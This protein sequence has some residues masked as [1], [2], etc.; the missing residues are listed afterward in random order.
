MYRINRTPMVVA[1]VL[2]IA[3]VVG[4]LVGTKIVWDR[5]RNQPVSLSSLPGDPGP[6][7]T[8]LLPHLPDA[9]AGYDRAEIIEPAPEGAAV[10]QRD[11]QHRITLRCGVSVPAQLTDNADTRD[12]DGVEW[13]QVSEGEIA[14]WYAVN[15]SEI[16][17]V[18]ASGID[19]VPDL[20]PAVA[21]LPRRDR[22]ELAAPE[23]DRCGAFMRDLP[24]TLADRPRDRLEGSRARWG[25]IG[26]VCGVEMPA[27]YGPGEHVTEI[28]GVPWFDAGDGTY[29]AL[30]LDVVV[31]VSLPPDAGDA[32]LVELSAVITR[33]LSNSG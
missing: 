16:V 27:G 24:D 26:V 11:S 23:S 4:V 9:V 29:F 18:T 7:C 32:P 30:G 20:S 28:D 6:A 22:A 14:T 19:P 13:F 3:L 5:A 15:R 12:V 25:D 8:E 1:L 21:T 33:V 31:A 10:W 17:A 2:A